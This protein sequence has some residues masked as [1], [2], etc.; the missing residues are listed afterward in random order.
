MT[1]LNPALPLERELGQQ[2]YRALKGPVVEKIQ[3]TAKDGSGD[4]H[5]RSRTE[6][7][8]MEVD[9]ECEH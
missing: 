5:W 7:H 2:I 8:C 9:N 6:G 1:T 3:Q 4:D